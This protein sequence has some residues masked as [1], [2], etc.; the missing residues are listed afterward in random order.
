MKS[1]NQARSKSEVFNPQSGSISG[2][3][4]SLL[5][6]LLEFGI[7]ANPADWK[8]RIYIVVVAVLSA[9]SFWIVGFRV[10][11]STIWWPRHILKLQSCDHQETIRRQLPHFFFLV[12]CFSYHCVCLKFPIWDFWIIVSRGAPLRTNSVVKNRVGEFVFLFGSTLYSCNVCWWLCL[13]L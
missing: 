4:F 8:L 7:F 1:W 3:I 13:C 12:I 2:S 6:S 11:V 5:R 9:V 10:R